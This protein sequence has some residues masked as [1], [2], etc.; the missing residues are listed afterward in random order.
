MIR[1]SQ[2]Q[3]MQVNALL[4]K[5][6]LLDL[7]CHACLHL[8]TS[9]G[10]PVYLLARMFET[11]KSRRHTLGKLQS[12]PDLPLAVRR[13]YSVE[14]A[15]PE[16][17]SGPKDGHAQHEQQ[18]GQNRAQPRAEAPA[19]ATPK[20]TSQHLGRN[21][22]K[23]GRASKAAT[24]HPSTLLAT[25]LH[26]LRGKRMRADRAAQCTSH[27]TGCSTTRVVW[28]LGKTQCFGEAATNHKSCP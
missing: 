6:Y 3:S 9:T 12:L 2:N 21:L 13:A 26:K 10:V 18:V 7:F 27:K 15:V 11:R 16:L 5:A 4:L 1:L 19:P 20:K 23:G 17:D 25:S 22:F 8:Q 24:H 14:A 28:P